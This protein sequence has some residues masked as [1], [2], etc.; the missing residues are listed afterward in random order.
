MKNAK[1]KHFW[2]SN[3]AKIL[4]KT[5]LQCR[6]Q[7][8]LTKM[9]GEVNKIMIKFQ[10]RHKSYNIKTSLIKSMGKKNNYQS[11]NNININKRYVI[12]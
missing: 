5:C 7:S 4:R 6:K 8:K 9:E 12:E 1:N 3:S 11:I 10:R 2:S